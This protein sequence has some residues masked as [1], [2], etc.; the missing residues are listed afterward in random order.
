MKR[1]ALLVV[2]LVTAACAGHGGTLRPPPPTSSTLPPEPA[3][4][5]ILP[6]EAQPLIDAG[7]ATVLDVR[8]PEE[9]W[10]SHLPGAILA[11][12]DRGAFGATVVDLPRD[13]TYIVYSAGDIRASEAGT[14][15]LDLGFTDVRD[16]I[17]GEPA[18]V[19]A[20]L[21]VETTPED[22]RIPP[23]P[24]VVP[25][26]DHDHEHDEGEEHD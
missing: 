16:L 21:P 6:P 12:L 1:A 15:L 5:P 2:L 3:V 4:V 26:D 24:D 22:Q 9:Y 18:W 23:N 17:G 14:Q 7:T 11:D 25:E 19:A 13:V 20:G 8:T 10:P